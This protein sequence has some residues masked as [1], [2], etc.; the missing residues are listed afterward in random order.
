T[1]KPAFDRRHGSVT[2]GNSSGL[3]DGAAAIVLMEES[4]AR[5]EGR[6]VLGV[7]RS[8]AYAA[9]PPEPQLLL[10]PALAIPRALSR[11]GLR[12]AEMDLVDMHEAFA[13]QMLSVTQA[14]ASK[15]FAEEQ[16]GK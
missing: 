6:D 12:L 9:L 4:R 13:A 3:T 10:G 14:L 11:A 1:L 15:R 2:A 5:A 7:L 16:L 8:Y